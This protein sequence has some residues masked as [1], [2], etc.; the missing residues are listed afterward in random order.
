MRDLR[1]S[2]FVIT[3]IASFGFSTRTLAHLVDSLIRVSRRAVDAGDGDQSHSRA[4]SEPQPIRQRV[5]T[6]GDA[7]AREVRKP[8]SQT[9]RNRGQAI[10]RLRPRRP[11]GKTTNRPRH[12]RQTQSSSPGVAK[13]HRTEE[14][15]GNVAGTPCPQLRV[16]KLGRAD[17]RRP[18]LRA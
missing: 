7:R 2:D 9:L 6:A 16:K 17:R 15:T 3:F 13:Y 18:G 12:M 14:M 8:P 4:A 1:P 5:I 10:D 11:P